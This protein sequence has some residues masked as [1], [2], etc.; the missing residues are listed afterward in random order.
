[1]FFGIVHKIMAVDIVLLPLQEFSAVNGYYTPDVG[2]LAQLPEYVSNGVC[3]AVPKLNATTYQ[4]EATCISYG[5]D[6]SSTYVGHIR[7]DRLIWF[8]EG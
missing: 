5:T 1:M 3:A 4:Y 8:T 2:Q 6:D 7:F